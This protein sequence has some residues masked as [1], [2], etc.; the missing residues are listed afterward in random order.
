MSTKMDRKQETGNRQQ[1]TGNRKNKSVGVREKPLSKLDFAGP[2]NEQFLARWELIPT[3]HCW[4]VFR[5]EGP[6]WRS[7]H[8]TK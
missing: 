1:E 4:I 5:P 8:P 2:E 6:C 3:G 7:R